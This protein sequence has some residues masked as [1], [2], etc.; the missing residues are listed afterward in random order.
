MK[1]TTMI[2]LL[3][4]SLAACAT[5]DASNGSGP[6]TS[7]RLSKAQSGALFSA[8][9]RGLKAGSPGA[10]QALAPAQVSVD[11]TFACDLGGHFDITGTYDYSPDSAAAQW[12][13]DASFVGCNMS[14]VTMDGQ[15]SWNQSTITA[16][17]FSETLAG[18]LTVSTQGLTTTCAFDVRIQT[19]PN[20]DVY[21]GTICG[22]DATEVVAEA[23]SGDGSI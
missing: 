11:S 23:P 21:S 5:D 19:G 9:V 4:L 15:L 3:S 17:S 6:A 12:D 22:Y 2:G 14:E 18:S 1:L 13:L 20:G 8:T 10:Q 16:G 7:S